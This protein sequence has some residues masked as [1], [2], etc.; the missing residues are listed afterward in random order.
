MAKLAKRPIVDDDNPEW[1]AEDFAK[2]RPAAEVLTE[3]FPKK[4]VAAILK[5]RG[6]LWRSKTTKLR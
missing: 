4:A 1:K 6:S 3:I 5:P 2:A